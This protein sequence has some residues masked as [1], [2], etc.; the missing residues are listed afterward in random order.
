[1]LSRVLLLL[2]YSLQT[3]GCVAALL[4][5]DDVSLLSA[6]ILVPAASPIW[7]PRRASF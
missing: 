7:G 6:L 4:L 1:M 5:D 3:S 2:Y